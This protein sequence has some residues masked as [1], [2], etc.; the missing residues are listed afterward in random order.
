[1]NKMDH[2]FNS[3]A[4]LMSNLLRKCVKNS[5]YDLVRLLEEY[6]D[7]NAYIGEY[8]IFS[9]L[10]LPDMTHLVTVFMVSD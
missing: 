10:A 8:H 3:V 9:R 4:S 1:M 2:F 5:I 7:G 6:A